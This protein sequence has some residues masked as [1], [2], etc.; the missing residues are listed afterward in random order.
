MK[1][2]VLALMLVVLG[3]SAHAEL[4]GT[5][6]YRNDIVVEDGPVQIAG[7]MYSAIIRYEYNI[8]PIANHAI[9][10]IKGMKKVVS[11]VD[12]ALFEVMIDCNGLQRITVNDSRL[13]NNIGKEVEV[14]R[15]DRMLESKFRYA[16]EKIIVEKFCK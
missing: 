7:N 5:D 14:Y 2:L 15:P 12:H 10:P 8:K 9:P 16:S 11:Y 4:V 1:K 6:K 3:Q 13:F